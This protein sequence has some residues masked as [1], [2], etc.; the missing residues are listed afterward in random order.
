VGAGLGAGLE[1]PGPDDRHVLAAA[2][3]TSAQVIVA[4]NLK[5]FPSGI[6]DKFEKVALCV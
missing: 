1:L 5:D 3:T 2:I 4:V 6:F